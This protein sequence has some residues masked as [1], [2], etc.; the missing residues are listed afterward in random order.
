VTARAD[1]TNVQY[2]FARKKPPAVESRAMRNYA[3]NAWVVTNAPYLIPKA[4]REGISEYPD[5]VGLYAAK[6]RPREALAQAVESLARMVTH[7][8]SKP[9][10]TSRL[11]R[12]YRRTKLEEL[13][14]PV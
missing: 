14:K 5:I 8:V 7:V 4:I 6:A 2:H 3:N 10:Q 9:R 1:S 12:Q 13:G 11:L